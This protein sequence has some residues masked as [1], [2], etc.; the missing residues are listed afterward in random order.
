MF[1]VRSGNE[2]EGELIWMEKATLNIFQN[3]QSETL[4][5]KVDWWKP[6]LGKY[7]GKLLEQYWV[8]KSQ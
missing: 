3:D 5:A 1:L 6:S 7:K 8:P 2:D 4:H